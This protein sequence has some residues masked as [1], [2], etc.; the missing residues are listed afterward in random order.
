MVRKIHA[1]IKFAHKQKKRGM[2]IC[3]S[4]FFQ[5]KVASQMIEILY[6]ETEKT[7]YVVGV[8]YDGCPLILFDKNLRNW[9]DELDSGQSRIIVKNV[10]SS[11]LRRY[12]STQEFL[13]FYMKRNIAFSISSNKTIT[14]KPEVYS[15]IYFVYGE[16]ED[17]QS[18][19]YNNP[20][21]GYVRGY[22]YELF[23]KRKP[24]SFSNNNPL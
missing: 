5:T 11:Y 9:S 22:M 3:T 17:L 21:S 10:Y 15:S 1:R 4:L 20:N 16:V 14:I 8:A 7:D 18:H 13:A 6:W 23:S 19:L 12:K 24:L 2:L